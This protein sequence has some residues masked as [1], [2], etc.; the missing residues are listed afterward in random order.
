MEKNL[1]SVQN[2]VMKEIGQR[3]ENGAQ[4]HEAWEY[5]RQRIYIPN[6]DEE[7]IIGG[8]TE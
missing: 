6:E 7:P 4:W 8:T 3:I 5:A 1:L 2:E